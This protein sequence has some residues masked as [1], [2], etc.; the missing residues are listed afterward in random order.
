LLFSLVLAGIDSRGNG[1]QKMLKLVFAA[2]A[3]LALFSQG[4]IA[5]EVDESGRP[6]NNKDA[7]VFFFNLKDGQK[8]RNGT[9]IHFGLTKMGV[10]PAGVDKKETGHHHLLVDDA[11]R[12]TSMKEEIPNDEKHLHFG[13]GQ[14]SW[15]V[16]LPPGDHKLQLVLADGGHIPHPHPIRSDVINVE[17]TDSD[18]DESI[19]PGVKDCDDCVDMVILGP[20]AFRMGGS[21]KKAESP[22]HPVMFKQKFAIAT[23][24]VT[25]GEWQMCVEDGECEP[26]PKIVSLSDDEDLPVGGVTWNQTSSFIDWLS[27]KSGKLYRLPTEAEWEY[28]ARAGNSTAYS[29]GNQMQPDRANC[30]GCNGKQKTTLVVSESLLPN[31]W[32]LYDMAGNIAEW[33]Q[34]CWHDSYKGDA[35]K[36]GSAWVEESCDHRVLKGGSANGHADEV[37]TWSR[38]HFD[39]D[40]PYRYNGFRVARDAD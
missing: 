2:G 28:A 21:T 25:R 31:D 33:V 40:T 39:A 4:S 16:D 19:M 3:A 22:V 17:V 6:M 7:E 9:I 10:A 38:G 36:D 14:T 20:G 11:V 8:I 18:A 30:I 32:G 5:Q 29:W 24:P 13:N 23:R 35:P 26:V 12:T 27:E 34:D 1:R 15:V 37:R